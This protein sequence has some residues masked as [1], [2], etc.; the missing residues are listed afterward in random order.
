MYSTIERN[1]SATGMRVL[2]VHREIKGLENL[3]I[4]I[5][6]FLARQN[7]LSLI[8]AIAIGGGNPGP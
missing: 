3:E 6:S 4:S 5:V 7:T 2:S 8:C 1:L